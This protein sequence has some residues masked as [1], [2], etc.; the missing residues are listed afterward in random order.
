M[1]TPW[2][3]LE[4]CL[5][6]AR[7]HKCFPELEFEKIIAIKIRRTNR[8]LYQQV[9]KCLSNC[10]WSAK[11]PFAGNSSVVSPCQLPQRASSQRFE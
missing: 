11:K 8:R 5:P 1:K 7:T 4:P 3:E 9:A 10:I 2:E 6:A